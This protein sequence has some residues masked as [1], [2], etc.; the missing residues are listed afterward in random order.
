MNQPERA[1][2][3]S[4]F[5]RVSGAKLALY[6][7]GVGLRCEAGFPTKIRPSSRLSKRSGHRRRGCTP[8]V[9]NSAAI[10][11]PT[12]STKPG[13][14][15]APKPRHWGNTVPVCAV[16]S[17]QPFLDEQHWSAERRWHR[18]N[19]ADHWRPRPCLDKNHFEL[20]RLFL[21]CHPCQEIAYPEGDGKLGAFV[22]GHA[23]AFFV[24]KED[25]VT[26]QSTFS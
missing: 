3:C 13:S 9:R 12:R 18:T 6:L 20:T 11:A 22:I 10:A 5:C 23:H 24:W 2:P 19:A 15:V 26:R 16:E 17:V 7:S 4:F 8:T 14:N 1:V 21:R 25:L